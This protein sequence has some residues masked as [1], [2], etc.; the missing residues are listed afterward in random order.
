M[1]GG[2]QAKDDSQIG[3]ASKIEK[4]GRTL[5]PLSLEALP[6]LGMGLFTPQPA[7]DKVEQKRKKERAYG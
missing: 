3:Q 5:P 6:E 4:V 2:C 7:A 1:S